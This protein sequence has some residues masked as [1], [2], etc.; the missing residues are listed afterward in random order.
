[1]VQRLQAL[2][3]GQSSWHLTLLLPVSWLYCALVT[4]RREAYRLGLFRSV[5]LPARVVVIGNLTSGGT[6]KTPLVIAITRC[7][8]LAG[9]RV[10]IVTRGYGGRAG[11]WPQAV[12]AD[13]N[14]HEVG[15]EAPLLAG[16]TGAPVFAGPDRVTAGRAL[17]AA[18]PCDVLISDDGLQHYALQRDLEVLLIDSILGLGNGHC[19]PAGPLREPRSRLTTVDAVAAIGA[20]PGVEWAFELRAEAVHQV[21]APAQTASLESFRGDKVYAVAGIG[22]PQR[23]FEL[24]RQ[25]GLDIEERIF[26]DHHRFRRED[27]TFSRPHPVLMT[28]KDAVKCRDF[29]PRQCWYL[30]VTLVTPP[31]FDDWLLNRLA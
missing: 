27:L 26:A 24:L 12:T 22:N 15:D 9:Y 21:S 11:Q 13:S 5:R 29:A 30:P 25:A 7:L 10:G 17:L 20:F 19:L 28:E 23:F 1:M 31:A 14:P 3:Y 18:H 6:G 16:H 4:L 8:Q 2:W